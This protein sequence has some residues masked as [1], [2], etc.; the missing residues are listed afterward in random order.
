[1]S[2]RAGPSPGSEHGSWKCLSPESCC[3]GVSSSTPQRVIV[4]THAESFGNDF[5]GWKPFATIKD[6]TNVSDNHYC[7]EKSFAK[8]LLYKPSHLRNRV[9]STCVGAVLVVLP[10]YLRTH[11]REVP[12]VQNDLFC[13]C[14]RFQNIAKGD[15]HHTQTRG[16][17]RV[18]WYW[19]PTLKFTRVLQLPLGSYISRSASK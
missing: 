9:S 8:R 14:Q 4:K 10:L 11:F 1:M 3:R 15:S 12:S 5:W 7:L 16:S 17:A 13:K 2:L 18:L 19:R 6:K